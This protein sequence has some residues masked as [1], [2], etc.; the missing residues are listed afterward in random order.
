MRDVKTNNLIS[1]RISAQINGLDK[2][3]ISTQLTRKKLPAGDQTLDLPS[4]P[5]FVQTGA[6]CTAQTDTCTSQSPGAVDSTL[7]TRH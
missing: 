1:Q 7:I 6:G 3:V 2:R 4:W 5:I